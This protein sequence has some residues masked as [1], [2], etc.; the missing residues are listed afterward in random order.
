MPKVLV[1]ANHSFDREMIRDQLVELGFRT[2]DVWLTDNGEEA[3]DLLEVGFDIGLIL[4]D[5]G[6][7]KFGSALCAGPTLIY[8]IRKK[9]SPSE[10]PILILSIDPLIIARGQEAGANG[11]ADRYNVA[12]GMRQVC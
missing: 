4:V 6:L 9:F 10:V 8:K 11:A 2:D 1:V 7:V 12:E 5:G 3:V